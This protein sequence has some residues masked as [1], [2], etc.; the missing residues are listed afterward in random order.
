MIKGSLSICDEWCTTS[1]DAYRITN[2]ADFFCFANTLQVFCFSF[3]NPLDF[4]F[5]PSQKSTICSSV[6]TFLTNLFTKRT[7]THANAHAR[8]EMIKKD[9]ERDSKDA[10]SGYLDSQRK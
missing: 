7:D 10:N 8:E 2:L 1:C 5:G 9:D 4:L 3:T 6:L